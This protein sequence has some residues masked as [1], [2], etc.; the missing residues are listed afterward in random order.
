MFEFLM[1]FLTSDCSVLANISTISDNV[2]ISFET[3]QEMHF[4]GYG[5]FPMVFFSGKKKQE[6]YLTMNMSKLIMSIRNNQDFRTTLIKANTKGY[7]MLHFT[8]QK[9]LKSPINHRITAMQNV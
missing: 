4:S 3:L 6:T 2:K 5:L 1:K 8:K 7:V 9:L